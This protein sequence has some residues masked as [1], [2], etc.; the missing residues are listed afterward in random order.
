MPHWSTNSAAIMSALGS[1]LAGSGYTFT[2][3]GADVNTFFGQLPA[4]IG[5]PKSISTQILTR[6]NLA[7]RNSA[8]WAI[9]IQK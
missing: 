2:I 4:V 6:T 8:L 3:N 1:M 5:N 7:T 9:T